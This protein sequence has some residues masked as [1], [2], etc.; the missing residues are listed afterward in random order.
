MPSWYDYWAVGGRKSNTLVLGGDMIVTVNG[1]TYTG[2]TAKEKCRSKAV[3]IISSTAPAVT[4][5]TVS[6]AA[7]DEGATGSMSPAYV[8]AGDTYMLPA[9]GFTGAAGKAFAGWQVNGNAQALMT[10]DTFTVTADMTV[11]ALWQSVTFGNPD[12]M[13]PQN[14]T[15]IEA[16]AFEGIAA[17]VVEIPEYCTFIGNGAFKDCSKLTMIR[18]PA[19]CELG[20][21]VFDG[22]TKV[23]VFGT[24]GSPAEDYCNDPAHTNCVFVEDINLP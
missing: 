4:F 18:I 7:G 11:T 1:Q 12:F 17:T 2:A 8:L 3:V 24:A 14:T 9:C 16:N 5:R 15:R 22:C 6:F 21:D 13:I 19:D 20:T 10:G 23:Y